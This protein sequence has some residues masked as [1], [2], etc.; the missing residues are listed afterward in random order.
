MFGKARIKPGPRGVA[1]PARSLAAR[2]VAE[3]I[4]LGRL[5]WAAILLLG[6]S[7]GAV[8]W[9]ICQLRTDAIRT[10]IS[11]SGNIAAVLAGQLSRSLQSIDNVLLE[12]KDPSKD[13]DIDR[14][15]DFRA[16]FNRRAVFRSLIRYRDRLPQ[17]F[18]IALADE[19]GQVVV[20]T[21]DW[22]TPDVNVAD[23]DYF[24]EARALRRWVER[25]GS[26]RQPAQ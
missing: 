1:V 13:L 18:N 12:I 10:A 9:T 16:A 25:L 17:V 14:S 8:G 20:S 2:A 26:H 4:P 7:V 24:N 15:L 21:A 11:D 6:L 22:P 19:H 3:T 23:R 5:W